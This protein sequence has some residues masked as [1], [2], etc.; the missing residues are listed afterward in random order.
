[1]DVLVR[2][3]ERYA[4]KVAFDYCRYLPGGEEHSRLTYRE[5]DIKARAIAAVLQQHGLAGER[6]LVLCPSGLDFLAGFF[7]CV[8]AGPPPCR[9]IRRF[10]TG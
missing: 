1:M 7:G 6:V 10:A 9:C 8:Y 4:D 2:N 3:A 5:L